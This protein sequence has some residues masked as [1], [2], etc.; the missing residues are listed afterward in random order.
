MNFID[1][2]YAS[3]ASAAAE[4]AGE[5]V[6]ASLG[7]NLPLFLIQLLN[8]AAVA[9]I[10]WFLILKPLTKKMS[11][12]QKL[13]EESLAK[14]QKMDENLKNSEENK[15]RALMEARREGERIISAS[16]D[17]AKKIGEEILE[18]TKKQAGQIV[19]AAKKQVEEEK[20]RMLAEIKG[21][22]AELVVAVVEKIL[23]ERM[24]LEKDQK[25]IEEKIQSF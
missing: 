25:F 2:V 3:E 24:N 17:Q 18:K 12:R 15:K 13:I 5:G 22:T 8:F 6:L 19:S 21:Q 23:Q 10:L 9:L 11:E 20:S 7:L 4:K 1:I 16:E 14:A